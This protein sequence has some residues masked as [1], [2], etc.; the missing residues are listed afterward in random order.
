MKHNQSHRGWGL[1]VVGVSAALGWGLAATACAGQTGPSIGSESHFLRICD[2]TCGE[3]LS[4]IQGLCTQSCLVEEAN[5]CDALP[6]GAR[7]TNDSGEPGS[8]ALCDVGCKKS[9]DCAELSASHVC[10]EGFCR[11]PAL[12]VGVVSGWEV[13]HVDGRGK[14]EPL[15]CTSE[16]GLDA[17]GKLPCLMIEAG[18]NFM[19]SLDCSLDGLQRVG[20]DLRD[21]VLAHMRELGICDGF[22]ETECDDQEMCQVEQLEGSEREL[23]VSDE[24]LSSELPV[25]GFCVLDETAQDLDGNLIAGGNESGVHPLLEHCPEGEQAALRFSGSNIPMSGSFVFMAC[26]R[27]SSNP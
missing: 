4:C 11:G 25:I 23:C 26:P 10:E 17:E 12:Q 20:T 19:E 6:G 18:S 27:T 9:A 8:V 1:F 7:C 16:G 14:E 21:S 22:S 5:S 13:S 3:E 24:E 2:G 15:V